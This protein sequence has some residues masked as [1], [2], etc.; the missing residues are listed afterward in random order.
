MGNAESGTRT[1]TSWR[2]SD[3][4]VHIRVRKSEV[5]RNQADDDDP[6]P[7]VATLA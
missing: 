7:P 3:D 1:G 5:S 6:T 2:V 4:E